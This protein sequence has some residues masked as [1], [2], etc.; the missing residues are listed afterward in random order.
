[1]TTTRNRFRRLAVVL[2]FAAMAGSASS[3]ANHARAQSPKAD[4][5]VTDPTSGEV[6]P[7]TV[8]PPRVAPLQAPA[9]NPAPSIAEP[10]PQIQNLKPTGAALD[11]RIALQKAMALYADGEIRFGM[12]GPFS[13][14]SKEFGRQLAIGI[15]T[16]FKAANDGAVAG[17]R[18]LRLITGD[19]GYEASRTPDLVRKLVEQDKVAG[20]VGSFGTANAQAVLPWLQDRQILFYAPF[21]GASVV[22]ANPPDALVFNF[23]PSYAEETEAAVRYL[24]TV[25]GVKPREIAV[26]AQDD[27]F[28]QAGYEGAAKALR[29]FSGG[30][31]EQPPLHLTYKRNTV[32][33]GD[34]VASLR[35]LRAPPKAVIIVGLYRPAAKFIE[36]VRN[37]FPNMIFTNVSAVGASALAEELVSAGARYAEGIVVTQA[38][39]AVNGYSKTATEFKAA[40]GQ[41]YPGEQPDYLSFEGY[42]EAKLLIEA[43]RRA[44]PGSIDGPKLAQVLEGM[45]GY[46]MGLGAPVTFTASDHQ[47]GHTI[48][49]TMMDSSGKYRAID[50]K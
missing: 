25:R 13:G 29:A 27:G 41:Y 8:S 49:A 42:V 33:V 12:T 36:N 3:V 39:P 32:D 28:G 38:V 23:R 24:V 6:A 18:K 2:A 21:T 30:R 47:A 10:S 7:K 50:F 37:A 44:G 26:F 22:R 19:D 15:E 31:Y 40:L 4:G 20:F 14:P 9:Q 35:S 11:P 34:A 17:A 16:A 48:W 43:V 5:R 45:T 46:D 1:M